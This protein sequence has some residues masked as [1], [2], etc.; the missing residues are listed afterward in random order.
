[1]PT[2]KFTRR[3]DILLQPHEYQMLTLLADANHRTASSYLRHLIY[4]A[5]Q[6]QFQLKPQC[7]NGVS[8]PHAPSSPTQNHTSADA[9]PKPT[10]P[11]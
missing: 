9:N 3:F 8:C 1:M 4:A 2:Q 6:H 11:K 7:A 10:K 5:H